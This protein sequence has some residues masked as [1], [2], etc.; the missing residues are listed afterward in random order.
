VPPAAPQSRRE[1]SSR[2]RR[3]SQYHDKEHD[4]NTQHSSDKHR[5][6][7]VAAAAIIAASGIVVADASDGKAYSDLLREEGYLELATAAETR[8]A[9]GNRYGTY[10]QGWYVG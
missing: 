2:Q 5:L 3:L 7:A 10:T 9:C 4:M 1:K 6:T 8:A